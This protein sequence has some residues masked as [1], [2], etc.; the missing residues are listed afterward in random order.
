MEITGSHKVNASQ[1]QVFQ[2][3]LD[4]ATLKECIPGCNE[5]E[6]TEVSWATGRHIRLGISLNIPG[7]SGTYNVFIKPEDVIEPSHLVLISTPSSAV[8]SINARCVVDLVDEGTQTTVNYATEAVLE[9]KVA[10][11]PEFVVKPAV[12]GELD[13]F[14]KNLEKHFK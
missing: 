8:G 13:R 9:G 3:L 11:L 5:A 14:F 6:Y 10:A 2:A 4:P 12:K 7:M 1:L